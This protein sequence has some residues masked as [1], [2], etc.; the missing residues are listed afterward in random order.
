[1]PLKLYKR[2]GVWHYR[3]T[4]NKRRLRGSTRT[5]DK[6]RAQRIAAETEARAWKRDL[7]GP[8]AALRFSDCAIAYR[9]S[10]KPDRF[11]VKVE[12][13]WK[14]TLV[15]D[16]KSEDVRRGANK[17]Y[18]GTGPATRNRQF[19][20]PT[21]AIVN[22]AAEQGWCPYLKVKRFKVDTKIKEPV[23]QE[24]VES[25]ACHASPHLGA[26]CLFM[27]GTGARISESI[28]L[29]WGD[30]DLS[31]ATAKI[32][33]T[34]VG[35]ERIAHLAPPVVAAMAN[36]PSNRNLDERVFLYLDRG[37]VRWSW[38]AAIKRANIKQLSPHCCR[39]GFATTML[40]RGVDVQ[41]VAE[42]GGWADVAILVRT[43]AHAMKDR[44]VTNVLFDTK[45][46]PHAYEK[47]ASAWKD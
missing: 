8:G 46:T 20:V 16:I 31:A 18:P 15:R 27:Y 5:S 29:R 21:Q 9:D 28:D 7:D 34:K 30:L 40:R 3:G 4:V 45:P 41:T 32:R 19:I 36:I 25:F 10:G 24:W 11:L 13:H 26:L 23:T 1:M 12:D 14:D 33:Q 42:M 47:K 17:T 6:E 38:N 35:R 39:H 44:T 43:Y 37:N 2:G 22:Y